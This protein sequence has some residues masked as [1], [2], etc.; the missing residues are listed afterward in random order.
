MI[1]SILRRLKRDAVPSVFDGLPWYLNEPSSQ[2][3]SY[4]TGFEN[5]HNMEVER[6]EE[7]NS[8]FLEEDLVSDLST[9]KSKLESSNIPSNYLK[10][11][12]PFL[13]YVIN[14]SET[15]RLKCDCLIC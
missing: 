9:L 15:P 12:N 1:L 11:K 5:R 7:A 8:S 6:Q 14:F 2:R 4:E 3:R 10:N 13:F